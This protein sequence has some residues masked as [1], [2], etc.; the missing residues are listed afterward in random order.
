MK[1]LVAML[2]GVALAAPTQTLPHVVLTELPGNPA[3]Q[4][5]E[6]DAVTGLWTPLPGFP[7]DAMTP[8]A[9]TFDRVD[10]AVLVALDQG[11]GQSRI[12]STG[13]LF[14]EALRQ[15]PQLVEEL[16]K[17]FR[18]DGRGEH[19]P[20]SP[21]FSEL[22]PCAF[23]DGVLRTFYHSEYMRSVER[24]PGV[25]LSDAQRQLLDLYD[26]SAADPAVHL[27]MWLAPGDV[28]FISNHTIAHART[29]YSD[30]P[31]HPRHLLRLWLS[32]E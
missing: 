27:D 28:Q 16:F 19:R 17:P 9:V 23:A 25:V 15:A 26:E 12:V 3:A 11:G 6:V 31:D 7:S 18:L 14:N 21:P 5:V 22:A 13:T 24:H 32:L 29:A 2:L 8:L 1:R 4:L 10:G 20:G 30:D